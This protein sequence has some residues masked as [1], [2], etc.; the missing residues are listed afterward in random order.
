MQGGAAVAQACFWAELLERKV[1]VRGKTEEL[2]G[3]SDADCDD[4]IFWTND[5]EDPAVYGGV[6]DYSEDT[7][8]RSGASVRGSG[9]G[10]RKAFAAATGLDADWAGETNYQLPAGRCRRFRGAGHGRPLASTRAV[11]AEKAV[12]RHRESARSSGRR[13]DRPSLRGVL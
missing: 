2:G 1:V 3:T 8:P 9:R 7:G 4:D 11:R 12:C 13:V 5:E 10:A 6:W